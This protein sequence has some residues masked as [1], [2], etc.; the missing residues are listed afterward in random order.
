[1]NK[2]NGGLQ[3]PNSSCWMVEKLIKTSIFL[4]FLRVWKI[5]GW[6]YCISKIEFISFYPTQ[7]RNLWKLLLNDQTSLLSVWSL[8]DLSISDKIPIQ[9]YWL[10]QQRGQGLKGWWSLQYLHISKDK[11]RG[12]HINENAAAYIFLLNKSTIFRCCQSLVWHR[13]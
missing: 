10:P 5:N 11:S 6:A 7:A 8:Q 2:H 1:M 13:Y 9:V 3:M 4:L 12:S